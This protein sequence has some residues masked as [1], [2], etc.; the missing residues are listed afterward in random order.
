MRSNDLGDPDR[1]GVGVI[2]PKLRGKV[3]VVTG[4]NNPKGIGAAVAV[5]LAAQGVAVFLT[6]LREPPA[7]G[8]ES[9]RPAVAPAPGE[10]FYRV[11]NAAAAD[12]VVG[13]VRRHGVR[14]GALEID[15]TEPDAAA[16]LFNQAEADL[17]PVAVL[18]ANAA[19]SRPDGFDPDPC[20]IFA[21][22]DVSQV[23][24]AGVDRH[25]A[26]NARANALLIA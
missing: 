16:R 13:R 25:F 11:Q 15:L 12:A 2:D 9:S 21:D 22:R 10:A 19:H 3:A 20:T 8:S 18:V 14:C 1:A 5:A 23:T 26:V 17:G 7:A 6:Y 24:A 4:A